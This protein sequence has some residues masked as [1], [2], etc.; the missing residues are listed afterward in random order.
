MARTGCDICG[1]V[2]LLSKCSQCGQQCCG[3][4]Y[5][6][7]HALCASCARARGIRVRQRAHSF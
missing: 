2:R 5:V 3:D 1:A 6:H 7:E 4:C